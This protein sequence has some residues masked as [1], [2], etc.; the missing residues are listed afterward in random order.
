M[1]RL[2]GPE[3]EAIARRMFKPRRP[4]NRWRSHQ[5][6]LGQIQ[7]C[8]GQV[9]D[10]V[11]VSL[12]RAPHS[13]TREDVVEINCHSGYLVLRRIL[14]EALARGARLA[15]PGEFTLRAFLSGRLDLTQAEAVLEVIQARTEN[16][17]RVA[18]SHLQGALSRRLGEVREELLNLLAQVEAALDFPEEA[19]ELAPDALKQALA[20]PLHLLSEFC[21]TYR[22]GRLLKEGLV[23]VIA[24]RPNVGKSSL[25][26]R[27]LAAERAIVTEFPGT[28]RDVI[29][30]AVNFQ[31]IPVRLTDTAG[32]RAAAGDR[33]EELGIARTRERLMAADVILY[34]VDGN[35][36]V[37]EEDRRT[38]QEKGGRP[39]LTVINKI[40]LPQRVPEQELK[41]VT[42]WPLVRISALTSQG[43][44]DLRQAIVD[45]ALAGGV[46][47]EGEII[48]QTRHHQHLTAGLRYLVKGQS[49]LGLKT[50]W[51]LVAEELRAAIHELGEITGEE[52]GEDIL[53]RIFSQFCIG[54]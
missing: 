39:G 23:V 5:L 3:A 37:H 40:D 26:N 30:E 21:D 15:R 10:E 20:G 19:Q 27:L 35:Q 13:Y 2:S 9:I 12:M 4:L 8:R 31:G 24:G 38:L 17:L 22:E 34:M 36:P 46:R 6:Y 32:L 18:S 44:D 54:K 33:V 16:A 1:V 14:A 49:L 29:E 25:L 53:D 41:Q 42:A 28:T 43:L 50:P 7:D 51:E 52:V 48:T 11:L 45:L 47:H